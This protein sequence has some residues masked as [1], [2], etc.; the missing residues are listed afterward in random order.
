[1][2]GPSTSTT[3]DLSRL[4]APTIVEQFDYETILARKFARI[5]E[6]IPTFDATVDSDPAVKVL[7][8]AAYDELLIRRAFQD[9][10]KQ[11]MVAFATGASLDHLGALVGVARLVVTPADPATGAGTVYESDDV[12]RQRIVLAPEAFSVAGPELAYVAHA[13]AASGDVI[14]ASAVSPA[15]GEVLVSVLSAVGDGTAAP[16]LIATV[17]AVVSDRAIRPLGD[18]VVTASAR[19]V[20]FAIDAA[21]TTY[22]GPDIVLVLTTAR[23]ALDAYLADTRRLGFNIR[24]AGIVAALKVAGVE[25]V[26]LASPA[27]DIL[28]TANEA[29]FCA[30]IT[31]THAGYAA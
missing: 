21:L 1:M 8:V 6:L 23:A 27:T 2:P 17:Q 31:L 24:T 15:P 14:D 22:A 26:V 20:P 4:P 13:K 25:N 7:Q 5:R 28:C 29:A 3:V 12:F 16:A 11:L 10:G 18:H 9:S 30:T 19:I